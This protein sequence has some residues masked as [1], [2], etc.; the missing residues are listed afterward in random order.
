MALLNL[1]IIQT[2]TGVSQS[3]IDATLQQFHQSYVD[4]A[5][6]ATDTSMLDIATKLGAP[7][8]IPIKKKEE[9]VAPPSIFSPRKSNDEV[10]SPRSTK[11][12]PA[13]KTKIHDDG[14]HKQRRT[15]HQAIA[16]SDAEPVQNDEQDF[17]F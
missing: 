4:L 7:P 16:S 17:N 5:A 2:N 6:S 11:E 9:I 1:A 13:V 8:P 15:K 10:I 3:K 14:R 12:L